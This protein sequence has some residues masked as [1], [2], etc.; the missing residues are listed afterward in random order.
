M[1]G[2]KPIY[3]YG[4][5]SPILTVQRLYIFCDTY[6]PSRSYEEIVDR[7]SVL[8]WKDKSLCPG[9]NNMRLRSYVLK[10][11]RASVCREYTLYPCAIEFR[12]IL[13]SRSILE[14]GTRRPLEHLMWSITG[15]IL[16]FFSLIHPRRIF[17]AFRLESSSTRC[18]RRILWYLRYP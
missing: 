14:S 16:T 8:L 11:I 12:Y 17:Y 4:E 15:S 6:C 1:G 3:R 9:R 5:S 2:E 18:H 10:D 7:L 13:P